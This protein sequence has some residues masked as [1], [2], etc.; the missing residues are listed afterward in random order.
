MISS[1]ASTDSQ[2][3]RSTREFFTWIEP[4]SLNGEGL[5]I[6]TY[7]RHSRVKMIRKDM[8]TKEIFFKNFVWDDKIISLTVTCHPFPSGS[9]RA[10]SSISITPIDTASTTG[11]GTWFQ[12]LSL[13]TIVAG[14][15]VDIASIL[16]EMT[17]F[18]GT[19]GPNTF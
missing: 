2:D 19:V 11:L 18:L 3:F 1:Q 15:C 5:Q 4:S 14:A 10:V 7:T 6:L 17:T 9:T 8:N 13:D 16:T 12:K